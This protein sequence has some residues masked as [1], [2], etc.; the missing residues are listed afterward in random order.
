MHGTTSSTP[1]RRLGVGDR[2]WPCGTWNAFATARSVSL[3]SAGGGTPT[4]SIG[5]D[6]PPGEL[7]PFQSTLVA[8]LERDELLNAI[9]AAAAAFLE[10]LR[11]G[12]PELAG[13]LEG[14]LLEFVRLPR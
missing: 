13:R 4:S 12:G 10:E 3:K 5:Y 7:V 1:A 11:H 9:E 8:A 6:L 2:G 14:P